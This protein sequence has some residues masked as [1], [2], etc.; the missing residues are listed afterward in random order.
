MIDWIP[1]ESRLPESHV[2]HLI[3]NGIWISLAVH[4][5]DTKDRVYKWFTGD[6]EP[7][8]DVTHFAKINYPKE[9]E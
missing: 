4:Q 5:I 3:S 1:Y 7:I 2:L 8:F 6:G 9:G